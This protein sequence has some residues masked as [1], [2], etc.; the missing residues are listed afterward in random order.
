MIDTKELSSSGKKKRRKPRV[1]NFAE[2]ICLLCDTGKEEGVLVSCINKEC[3]S[4]YHLTCLGLASHPLGI[5][6]FIFFQN[7]ILYI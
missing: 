6:D 7:L 1:R 5:F 3:A 4:K 2:D